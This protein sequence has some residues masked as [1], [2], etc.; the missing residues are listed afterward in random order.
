MCVF[1]YSL[2]DQHYDLGKLFGHAVGNADYEEA[3]RA[4][5]EGDATLSMSLYAR[6]NLSAMEIASYQLEQLQTVDLS[7]IL[8][9][10]GGPLVESAAA[11]PYTDGTNFVTTPNPKGLGFSVQPPAHRPASPKAVPPPLRCSARRSHHGRLHTR[12]EGRY[13]S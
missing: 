7:G 4:L 11:F 6:T 8:A 12:S 5:V 13:A 1:R 3:I 9:G 10:S 2:Q